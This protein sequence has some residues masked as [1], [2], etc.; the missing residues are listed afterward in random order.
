M[1]VEVEAALVERILENLIVNA[2][3]HSPP[4]ATVSVDVRRAGGGAVITVGDSGPGV[5]DNFKPRVFSR[6]FRLPGSEL[7]GS[8]LGLHLVQRF[9]QMHGGRVWVEDRKPRGASFRVFL[10]GRETAGADRGTEEAAQKSS[11]DRSGTA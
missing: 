1:A 3:K 5:S 2:L 10:P 4:H 11:D 8:G 7:P 6:H 9:A